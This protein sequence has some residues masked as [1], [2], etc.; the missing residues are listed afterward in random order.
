VFDL[1]KYK[2]KEH[3]LPVG[4]PGEQEDPALD[5]ALSP[6]FSLLKIQLQ[7]NLIQFFTSNCVVIVTRVVVESLEDLKASF[8]SVRGDQM[9]RRFWDPPRSEQ[10][11][12][13]RD[14]LES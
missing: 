3:A 12:Q 4:F 1:Q 7:A 6:T 13:G 2:S 10:E 14:D 8:L 5:P 9:A 11:A